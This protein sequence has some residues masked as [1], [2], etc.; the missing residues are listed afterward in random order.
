A[1][2]AAAF[3]RDATVALDALFHGLATHPR[4]LG[5]PTAGQR[6][7]EPVV[8][9]SR[10]APA[11]DPGGEDTEPETPPAPEEASAPAPARPSARVAWWTSGALALLLAAL[12]SRRRR[13]AAPATGTEG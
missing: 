12:R 11:P 2:V 4:H 9:P 5:P 6:V 10:P 8:V 13:A 3:E 1:S 7:P